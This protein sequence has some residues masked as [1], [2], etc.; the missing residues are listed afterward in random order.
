MVPRNRFVFMRD[1]DGIYLVTRKESPILRRA[2]NSEH[3][4]MGMPYIGINVS[5]V[6]ASVDFY[7]RFGY[8]NV[9]WINQQTLT[10]EESAVWASSPSLI[11]A[12]MSRLIAATAIVC[13]Y[14]SG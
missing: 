2:R 8:T 10:A 13:G 5:D 1:P 4:V 12:L 6:E 7:R 9:R 11:A 14:S 3:T